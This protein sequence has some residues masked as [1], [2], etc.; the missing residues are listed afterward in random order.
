M[1]RAIRPRLIVRSLKS[2]GLPG[3]FR[4]SVGNPEE[5]HKLLDALGS[6]VTGRRS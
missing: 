5:N 2:Y 1:T 6:I 3:F 4:I